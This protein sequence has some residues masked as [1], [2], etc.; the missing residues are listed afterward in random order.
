MDIENES[1][2]E[3]SCIKLD[4][5]STQNEQEYHFFDSIPEN[6]YNEA[7]DTKIANIKMNSVS[8]RRKDELF[9]RQKREQE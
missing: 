5:N 9:K 4:A 7:L 1:I 6:V 8:T 3:N 2:A